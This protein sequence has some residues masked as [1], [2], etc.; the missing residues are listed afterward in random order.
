MSPKYT[1]DAELTE[2]DRSIINTSRTRTENQNRDALY[3]AIHFDVNRE[4]INRHR[5]REPGT[6]ISSLDRRILAYTA[7]TAEEKP[8]D[9]WI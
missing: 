4:Y 9:W 6:T 1:L 8:K 3:E 2:I 5:D 7:L